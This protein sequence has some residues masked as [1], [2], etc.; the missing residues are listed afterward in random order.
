VEG[1]TYLPPPA[2][3]EAGTPAI[4]Q[5]IGLGA[6]CDYLTTLGMD[7]VMEYEHELGEYLYDRLL[8]VSAA[9]EAHLIPSF[10][11]ATLPLRV[12][13]PH[14][15]QLGEYLYD[16]L[17]GVRSRHIAQPCLKPPRLQ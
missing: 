1:S 12:T 16:M 5:A 8:G 3:F 10:K 7:A 4:T 11:P 2:R 14:E 9:G 15:P 6:A 13:P 17:S